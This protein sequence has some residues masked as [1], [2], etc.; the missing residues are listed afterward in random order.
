MVGVVAVRPQSAIRVGIASGWSDRRAPSASSK[1]CM[2]GGTEVS[3]IQ[4]LDIRGFFRPETVQLATKRK[5]YRVGPNVLSWPNI[6][7]EYP[8]KR[9][10]VGPTFEPTL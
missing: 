6:L 1:D 8:N 3:D 2:H 9:P 10:Q 4:R 5:S 7:T